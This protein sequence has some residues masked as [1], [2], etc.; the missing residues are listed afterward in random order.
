MSKRVKQFYKLTK[1]ELPGEQS[2]ESCNLISAIEGSEIGQ[3]ELQKIT[4]EGNKLEGKG[5]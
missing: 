1:I 5:V 2:K 4:A 3:R